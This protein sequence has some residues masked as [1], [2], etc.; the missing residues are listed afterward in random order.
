MFKSYSDN[1]CDFSEKRKTIELS[2]SHPYSLIVTN[3]VC[4]T[5]G[6]RSLF[7]SCTVN[8]VVLDQQIR[9]S[10]TKLVYVEQNAEFDV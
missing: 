10:S 4:P 2:Q 6:Q 1:G 5:A 3:N 7:L 9:H 8:I